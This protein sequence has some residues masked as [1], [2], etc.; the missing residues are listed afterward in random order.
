MSSYFLPEKAAGQ[1]ML[2]LVDTDC[3]TNLVSKRVFDCLPRH[4][5]DQRMEC[6][7]HGQ[8]ADG[9]RL[10]FYGVVQIPIRVRYVKSS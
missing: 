7:T 10:P 4:I 1:T 5:Q 8:I 9:T 6:D 3:N 2:Y